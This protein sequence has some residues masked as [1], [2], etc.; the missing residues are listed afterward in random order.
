ML[1]E[2]RAR[3]RRERVRL[4]TLSSS[5]HRTVY[6]TE[7]LSRSNKIAHSDTSKKGDTPGRCANSRACCATHIS[8][9]LGR[10]LALFQHRSCTRFFEEEKKHKKTHTHAQGVRTDCAGARDCRESLVSASER[11][12]RG[13]DVCIQIGPSR[14]VQAAGRVGEARPRAR[15]R[16]SMTRM[17]RSFPDDLELGTNISESRV[18][19]VL[20]KAFCQHTSPISSK[21]SYTQ[22]STPR[23]QNPTRLAKI[24]TVTYRRDLSRA[25]EGAFARLANS[26]ISP[27]R[28]NFSRKDS[29]QVRNLKQLGTFYLP[30]VFEQRKGAVFAR[31]QRRGRRARARSRSASR[32][33]RPR[34]QLSPNA[35]LFSRARGPR[36]F[37]NIRSIRLSQSQTHVFTLSKACSEGRVS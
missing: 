14:F 12:G 1:V 2:T 27:T 34:F 33:K 3:R 37:Q 22:S 21:A 5:L 26:R 8:A 7:V 23:F 18:T 19:R 16:V 28:H 32:E 31:G 10:C 11:V 25:A 36:L 13:R 9:F 4:S 17:S 20:C 29:F 15:P 30:Q 24:A 35:P 6:T